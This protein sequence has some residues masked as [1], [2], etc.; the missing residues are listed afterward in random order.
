MDIQMSDVGGWIWRVSR[1]GSSWWI[2]V[3]RLSSACPPWKNAYVPFTSTLGENH[4][5]NI[6]KCRVTDKIFILALDRSTT[7]VFLEMDSE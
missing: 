4:V 7:L 3:L 6:R 2:R 1:N 5:C